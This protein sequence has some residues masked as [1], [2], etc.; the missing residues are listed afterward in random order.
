MA[1][2]RCHEGDGFSVF[3]LLSP[4]PAAF[5]S[6]VGLFPRPLVLCAELC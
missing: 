2:P 1:E 5:S 3:L 4:R 6:G